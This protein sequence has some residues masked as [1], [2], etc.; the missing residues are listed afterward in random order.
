MSSEAKRL[1]LY[2]QDVM[3]ITGVSERSAYRLIAKARKENPHQ[4]RGTISIDH[5]I[6]LTGLCEKRIKS[7]LA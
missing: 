2:A 4:I 1:L 6:K 3:N 7:M 5:F